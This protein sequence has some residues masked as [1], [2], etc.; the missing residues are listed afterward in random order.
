MVFRVVVF[1]IIIIVVI[2]NSKIQ[3]MTESIK[4]WLT[5]HISKSNKIYAFL[6]SLTSLLAILMNRVVDNINDTKNN[7]SR[8]I[9]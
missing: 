3:M 8:T 7:L 1:K 5:Y 9:L 2:I 4:N 6:P